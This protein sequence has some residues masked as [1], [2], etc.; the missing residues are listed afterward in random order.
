MALK[1]KKKISEVKQPEL[2]NEKEY[3]SPYTGSAEDLLKEMQQEISPEATPLWQYINDNAPKIAAIVI[4]LVVLIGGYTFYS[5]YRE[6]KIDDAKTQLARIISQKDSAQI[7]SELEQFKA[8]APSE[9]RLAAELEI[10]RFASEQKDFA[11]AEEAYR[12]VMQEEKYSALGITAAM[13]TAGIAA[14]QGKY[15][16]AIKIYEDIVSHCPKDVQSV[17]YFQIGEMAEQT[18]NAD[19]AIKA[20]Q[21]GINLFENMNATDVIFYQN[22]IKELSK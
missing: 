18:G 9:L 5:G 14:H 20:Y 17:V 21:D 13:N 7:L 16:D 22:R 19:K 12:Y 10:A 8:G 3:Q 6:G 15:E 11:K 2:V 4:G 1:E